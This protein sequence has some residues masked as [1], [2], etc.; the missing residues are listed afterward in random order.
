MPP[1]MLLLLILSTFVLY[2]FVYTGALV[3][4]AKPQKVGVNLLNFL[5]PTLTVLFS[6]WLIPGSRMSRRLSAALVL[7]LA[8]VLL[9]NLQGLRE[10]LFQA[11]KEQLSTMPYVLGLM[12]GI[13]WAVYSVI[14]ARWKSWSQE[15]SSSTPGFLMTSLL[16]LAICTM[17]RS[18]E[19][20][21]P[22]AWIGTIYMAL[23][24][25]ASAYLLWEL[26]LH[27]AA[28]HTLGLMASANAVLS[29]LWMFAIYPFVRGSSSP[30]NVVHCL[31]GALLIAA[32]VV[33][34]TSTP[35]VAKEPANA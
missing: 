23:G 5:W 11:G 9:A 34:G 28:P 29:T 22:S 8:G 26:A 33:V 19:P 27:R 4:A 35:T 32:A 16:A 6:T 1:P 13:S 12:A 21:T 25:Q 10:L 2:M 18:W 3:I 15:Y 30:P 31:L 17:N 24:P 7:A 14:L 20:M